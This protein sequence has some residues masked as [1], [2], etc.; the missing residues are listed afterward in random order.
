LEFEVLA[1]ESLHII[2]GIR[3]RTV[4]GGILTNDGQE[5]AHLIGRTDRKQL[6]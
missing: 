6:R 3:G 1:S 5:A 2:F 4:W